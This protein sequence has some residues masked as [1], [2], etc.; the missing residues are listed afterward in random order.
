MEKNIFLRSKKN[1][2]KLRK[3][4]FMIKFFKFEIFKK[5]TK[6]TKNKNKKIGFCKVFERKNKKNLVKNPLKNPIF[7]PKFSE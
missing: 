1:I 7:S 6:T 3:K 4:L 2:F 5:H